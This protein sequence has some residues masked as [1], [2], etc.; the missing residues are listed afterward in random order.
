V[1]R[2]ND[3]ADDGPP[4]GTGCQGMG[5]GMGWVAALRRTQAWVSLVDLAEMALAG[6][7]ASW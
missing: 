2:L 3:L 7:G 6:F 4:S 1:G 5:R